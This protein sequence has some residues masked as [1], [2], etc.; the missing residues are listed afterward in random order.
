VNPSVRRF[1]LIFSV[2]VA[3][4][5]ISWAP[6]YKYLTHGKATAAMLLGI[7]F[8][9]IGMRWLDRINQQQRQISVGWL[10]LLFL[11]LTTAFAVLYPISLKHTLNAGSDRED[12]LRIELNAVHHHQYPYDAR[13]FLGNPP[14]PLPGAMLL[15]APFFALGH[16]AWQNFLWLV[17][18]FVFTIRFF[19][20]RVTALFFLAVFLLLAPANLSDFTS[21]GDYLTNF[22][23]L[24]IAIALFIWSLDRPLHACI[25]AALFFG[26]T[27]S[28]RVIYVVILIPLLALTLQRTS[29]FRAVALFVVVLIAAGAV[30]LPVFAP[31]AFTHLLQQL[32]QNATKLRYIPTALHPGW[33]LPLLAMIVACTT[34]FVRMSFPRLL[35]TFSITSFVML[36]P[37]VVSFALHSEKLRYNF[38]YLGVCTLSFSLW[39]LSR[40]ERISMG[41]SHWPPEVH[42]GY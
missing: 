21:G 2:C 4:A 35:L 30:T 27:L 42:A 22:F 8:I 3:W 33:T 32:D 34:F 39:A 24:V 10:L 12:A 14:T 38:S 16:I 23:Y 40:Y 20:H 31:H 29:R 26:V 9:A 5:L 36:A 11:I 7:L 6:I 25:P 41:S 18:F 19:R 17:L 37:F 1:L 15:A 28:S 13:T